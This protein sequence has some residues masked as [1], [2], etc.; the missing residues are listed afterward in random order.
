MLHRL[1]TTDHRLDARTDLL[2]LL[3]Q[4][5]TLGGQAIETLTQR[6]ILFPELG[7]HRDQFAETLLEQLKPLKTEAKAAG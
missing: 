6:P 5:G 1:E 4:G 3:K 7:H 2:I